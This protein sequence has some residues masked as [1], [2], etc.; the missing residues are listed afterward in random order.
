MEGNK[1]FAMAK[2]INAIT[3]ITTLKL[4]SM[5]IHELSPESRDIA[6]WN[7]IDFQII[8]EDRPDAIAY[9]GNRAKLYKEHYNFFLECAAQDEYNADGSLLTITV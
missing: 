6:I 5:K 4:Y 7:E 8:S 1:S 2:N 9:N 3:Q